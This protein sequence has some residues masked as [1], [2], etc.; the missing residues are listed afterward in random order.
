[1]SSLSRYS[2][3][4]GVFASVWLVPASLQAAITW[5]S[6]MNITGD[7]DIS[8]IG[9]LEYAYR[10]ELTSGTA[11]DVTVNGVTFT[12][13]SGSG[14]VSS[15]FVRTENITNDTIFTFSPMN[16][17]PVLS[18]NHQFGNGR[19]VGVVESPTMTSSY[20]NFLGGYIFA[21]GA[22]SPGT[23]TG[24]RNG[25]TLTLN[26]L[27]IGKEYS[28]QVWFNDSRAGTSVRQGVIQGGPTIDYNTSANTGTSG[29]QGGL[30]QYAVGTFV[31]TGT[32]ED[33]VFLGFANDGVGAQLNGFQLRAIPEPASVML[34]G[35]GAIAMGLRRRR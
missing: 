7:T 3:F 9:D 22:N 5:G 34:A 35:L 6:A 26:G 30:G 29:G 24:R 13:I 2:A 4:F 27:E 16:V 8:T 21:G 17:S 18:T 31:A 10:F 11:G 28:V 12:S 25:Y 19:S 14:S 15:S 32:T 20:I 1:M 23:V 33:V